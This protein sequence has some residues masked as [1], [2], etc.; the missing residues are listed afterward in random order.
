MSE[1]NVIDIQ[2]EVTPLSDPKDEIIKQLTELNAA[3]LDKES[4]QWVNSTEHGIVWKPSQGD[5]AGKPLEVP[6]SSP[7]SVLEDM[8][9]WGNK[10]DLDNVPPNSVVLIKLNVSD[11]FRVNMMQRA[12]AKQVLEPRIEKLKEKKVC[13]LFM[14]EGD[15]ISV[16]TEEDMGKAGWAKKEPSRIITL[17]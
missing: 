17:S 2:A 4:G 10:L 7:P 5:R 14:Q 13:I 11:P 6:S 3:V 16:M 1:N 8:V 9:Q 15:D 12:I